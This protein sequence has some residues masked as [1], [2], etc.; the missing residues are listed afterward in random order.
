[1]LSSADA[2]KQQ[3]ITVEPIFKTVQ[4]QHI[5]SSTEDSEVVLVSEATNAGLKE[6]SEQTSCL[7]CLPK[8]RHVF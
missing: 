6:L 4:R 5:Y 7:T 3:N 1:M 8:R 2:N